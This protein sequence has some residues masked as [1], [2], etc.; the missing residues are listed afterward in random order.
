MNLRAPNGDGIG[1]LMQPRNT[2][3]SFD[4]SA[5]PALTAMYHGEL[6]RH[7]D[8]GRTRDEAH[9]RAIRAIQNAGW[10]KSQNGWKQVHPDLRDKVNVSEAVKQPDGTYFIEGV[11][12]FYPNA[13]KGTKHPF[14][15]AKI[16]QIVAN[17]NASIHSGSTP[18]GIIEGHP[19]PIDEAMQKQRE[20]HGF[21]VNW[22]VDPGSGHTVC[23][24][25][26]VHPDFVKRLQDKKLPG[27]SVGF[28]KDTDEL[29][30]RFGHVAL[31]G[32][33]SQALSYLPATDYY[34]VSGN[35]LLFSAD[36]EI[37]LK[38]KSTMRTQKQKDCFAALTQAHNAFDAAEMSASLGEPN[39]DS[40]MGEAKEAMKM[41]H[42]NYADAMAET[43]M[44]AGPAGNQ[45]QDNEC[46]PTV[47]NGAAMGTYG[48][49]PM[50]KQPTGASV[51]PAK[52]VVGAGSMTNSDFAATIDGI[53]YFNDAGSMFEALK[54][55]L[56]AQDAQ[57]EELK[58][59]RNAVETYNKGLQAERAW[60]Q[61]SAEIDT[62]RKG[63][64][65]VPSAE[66]VRE[67]FSACAESADPKKALAFQIKLYRS[68]PKTVTPANFNK[69][70]PMFSAGDAN[71]VQ[72]PKKTREQIR[73]DI[74]AAGGQTDD[75]SMAFA[76]IGAEMFD[77]VSD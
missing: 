51:S 7:M 36:T 1:A 32:G 50:A 24:F 37:F 71:P 21:A 15:A 6:S 16:K 67:Q 2:S 39:A 31:L 4:A 68:L 43:D 77:G 66:I 57:I 75:N 23:D 18:P 54:E 40:K 30:R 69:G 41:A 3:A 76:A 11:P 64:T 29:N 46:A 60:N 9:A 61:F 33:T 72:T 42:C 74:A 19:N 34:S 56:K 13:V 28:A 20:P 17:T 49:V 5:P 73:A 53:D 12:V 44:P 35:Y 47:S 14:D 58:A 59:S 63:G 45:V 27:L 70:L 25:S 38:G 26:R 48:D 55:R 65:P 22:R 10:Y 8:A 52:P 62:L